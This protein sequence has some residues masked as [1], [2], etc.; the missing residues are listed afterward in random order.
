MAARVDL[1][2]VLNEER[3]TDVAIFQA[4][5]VIALRT[6]RGKFGTNELTI[7]TNKTVVMNADSVTTISDYLPD[8][9]LAIRK[10]QAKKK[11]ELTIDLAQ[12]LKFTINHDFQCVQI[13]RYYADNFDESSFRPGLPGFAFTVPEAVHFFFNLF[14]SFRRKLRIPVSDDQLVHEKEMKEI[15]LDLLSDGTDEEEDEEKEEH[16]GDGDNDGDDIG[17]LDDSILPDLSGDWDRGMISPEKKGKEEEEQKEGDQEESKPKRK[18]KIEEEEEQEIIL[19]GK[20]RR[21]SD[22]SETDLEIDED[23]ILSE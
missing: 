2:Y 14:N 7:D 6:Y 1:S 17:E 16:N 12:N 13:R 10:L 20:Q 18:R 22:I 9:L 11:V 19:L 21:L 15:D 4:A 5:S 23:S 3:L 8:I